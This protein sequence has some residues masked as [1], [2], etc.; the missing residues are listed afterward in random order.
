MKFHDIRDIR[1]YLSDQYVNIQTNCYYLDFDLLVENASH[2]FRDFLH[3]R[4]FQ[5][6]MDF[7]DFD[8]DESPYDLIEEF[9][10]KEN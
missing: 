1:I 4:G 2:K 5:Y 6:G 10:I 7:E 9:E 8:T 3:D